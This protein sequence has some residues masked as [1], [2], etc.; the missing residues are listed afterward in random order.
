MT[1]QPS[2]KKRKYALPHVEKRKSINVGLPIYTDILQ[3]LWK[4]RFCTI[5]HL[6]T[7]LTCQRAEVNPIS[8]Q[9]LQSN[10][11]ALWHNGYIVK[12]P[13]IAKNRVTLGSEKDVWCLAERGAIH[14]AEHEGTFVDMIRY[15]SVP[16]SSKPHGGM[17]ENEYQNLKHNLLLTDTLASFHVFVRLSGQYRII[18][19]EHDVQRKFTY[20]YPQEGKEQKSFIRPD[21]FLILE[22]LTPNEHGIHPRANFFF[23][24]D[25]GTE[26][27]GDFQKKL[28]GYFFMKEGEPSP[29]MECMKGIYAEG[30]FPT[31]PLADVP[32]S[33][34]QHYRVLTITSTPKRCQNLVEATYT[35]FHNGDGSPRFLFTD[36]TKFTPISKCI[37][38]PTQDGKKTYKKY[39]L[40]METMNM[41]SHDIW[42]TGRKK[43]I[44]FTKLF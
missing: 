24:I 10:L 9:S 14:L 27:L 23:E 40:D 38:V 22:S 34:L 20:T 1:A 39:V 25:R 15:P 36:K 26:T 19:A 5:D 16:N 31:S 43:D 21:G 3:L 41:L 35:T 29:I 13:Q 33:W 6:A 28:S 18:Y 44:H 17:P 12:R 32:L 7:F 2:D 4:F 42:R 30:L 37:A 11:S 8:Y